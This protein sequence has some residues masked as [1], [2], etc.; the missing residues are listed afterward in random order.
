MQ[1]DFAAVVG[2]SLPASRGDLIVPPKQLTYQRAE[3]TSGLGA[4][5]AGSTDEI[6]AT[7]TGKMN[8]DIPIVI[9]MAE[10]EPRITLI[11]HT[12]IG[13]DTHSS[14]EECRLNPIKF[15]QFRLAPVGA[16]GLPTHKGD[17]KPRHCCLD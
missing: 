11:G 14:G 12:A 5:K 16:G 8:D 9:S 2:S 15:R 7:I 4:A 17:D 6:T 10:H 3:I 13:L 1:H